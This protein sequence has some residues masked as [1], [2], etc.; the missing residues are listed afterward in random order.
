M[1]PKLWPH[2]FFLF[3]SI[4]CINFI[5]NLRGKV[6]I[7][8]GVQQPLNNMHIQVEERRKYSLFK[9]RSRDS[10]CS[11]EMNFVIFRQV[12]INDQISIFSCA[13]HVLKKPRQFEIK[14]KK[15]RV[16][17]NMIQLFELQVQFLLRNV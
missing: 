4:P 12:M 6:F 17:R 16:K 14:F 5:E 11:P 8:A 7:G 3:P 1:L 10:S 2:V 15:K 9:F 13:V